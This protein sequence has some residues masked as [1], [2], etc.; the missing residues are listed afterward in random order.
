MKENQLKIYKSKYN[1]FNFLTHHITLLGGA[2]CCVPMVILIFKTL[3]LTNIPIVAPP[4]FKG[5]WGLLEVRFLRGQAK[6]GSHQPPI[7]PF[8]QDLHHS[9]DSPK[10]RLQ[11][12][13]LSKLDFVTSLLKSLANAHIR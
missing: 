10:H 6:R 4:Y 8:L 2:Y 11:E 3:S 13:R 7:L 1:L 5:A 12:N 9:K